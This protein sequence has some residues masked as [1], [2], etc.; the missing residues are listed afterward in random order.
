[1]KLVFLGP[2]GAGK[3]TMASRLSAHLNIPHISTGEIIRAAIRNET[4]LGKKVQSVVEAGNLVP[5]DLT[6]ELV[7]TRLTQPDAQSGYILDGFPRTIGQA[8]ALK[9][10]ADISMVINF[11]LSDDEIVRRLSGRRVHL[12]SGRTYHIEFNPPK[13]EN[14]DDITGE[15]L[16]IRPDDQPEAI[17]RRLDVYRKQTAP[18]I[19]YYKREGIMQNLD[20]RPKPDLVFETLESLVHDL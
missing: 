3:G 1:M 13:N 16:I 12:P 7:E 8:D 2:P 15:E 20:T 6:I 14:Q 18:L 17:R 11:E 5:D 19:E 9:Q 4:E 10:M